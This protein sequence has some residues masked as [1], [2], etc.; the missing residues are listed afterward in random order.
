MNLH[1]FKRGH[2][3]LQVSDLRER[4]DQ[5]LNLLCAERIQ[6][7]NDKLSSKSLLGSQWICWYFIYYATHICVPNSWYISALS[8]LRFCRDIYV[9]AVRY[10]NVKGIGSCSKFLDING[11]VKSDI[12][13]NEK[14]D[15]M[16]YK[17]YLTLAEILF[18][19]QKSNFTGYGW[20]W[21]RDLVLLVSE[22]IEPNTSV[23]D[24]WRPTQ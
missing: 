17:N 7:S 20:H 10:T 16:V 9:A 8:G 2:L 23:I 18:V 1:S 13:N 19:E 6:N 11:N 22:V 3:I 24:G 12:F 5:F 21:K 14:W 15:H 4:C